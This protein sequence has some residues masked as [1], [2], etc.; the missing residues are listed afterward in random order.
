M[1][2]PRTTLG[3]TSRETSVFLPPS[4]HKV[5]T[6]GGHI[7]TTEG[8]GRTGEVENGRGRGKRGKRGRGGCAYFDKRALEWFSCSVP[9]PA[10]CTV[11]FVPCCCS[12]EGGFR[13]HCL[14]LQLI[15][16]GI[17]CFCQ[18]CFYTYF[19]QPSVKR[20]AAAAG[21]LSERA[22]KSCALPG[23]LSFERPRSQ[24]RAQ[25]SKQTPNY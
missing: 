17:F 11:H 22:T 8:A 7:C 24:W 18:P 20:V 2:L 4:S 10:L 3:K 19:F 13:V 16:L 25:L 12:L 15:N 14:D 5:P 21:C 9:P 1:I 6:H 23:R